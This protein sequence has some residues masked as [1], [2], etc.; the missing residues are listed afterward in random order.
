VTETLFAISANPITRAAKFNYKSP[1]SGNMFVSSIGTQNR[2][3]MEPQIINQEVLLFTA[4]GFYCRQFC[5]RN[6]E[7]DS[8]YSVVEKIE[9][10]CWDG[11]LYEMLPELIRDFGSH[12]KSDIWNTTSGLNFLFINMDPCSVTEGKQTSI[13]PYF[14]LWA[15]GKTN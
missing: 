8:D 10:A 12:T 13:N 1:L 3:D 15:P 2:R 14:F 7:G 4:T 5:K 6:S 11:M 9:K